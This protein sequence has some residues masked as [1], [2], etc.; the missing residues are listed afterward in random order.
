MST[1][2]SLVAEVEQ[3]RQRVLATVAGVKRAMGAGRGRG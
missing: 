3:A 2:R 1:V